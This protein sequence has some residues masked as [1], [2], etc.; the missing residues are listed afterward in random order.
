MAICS[1]G[2]VQAPEIPR[3]GAP[4]SAKLMAWAIL[5]GKSLAWA[6]EKYEKS[7]PGRDFHPKNALA[8][9]SSNGKFLRSFGFRVWRIFEVFFDV[10]F[11]L[12]FCNYFYRFWMD[13]AIDFG[14]RYGIWDTGYGIR[15]TRHGIRDA[16]YGIRGTGYGIRDTGHGIRNTW[17]KIWKC[18]RK[19]PRKLKMSAKKTPHFETVSNKMKIL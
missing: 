18:Q 2:P 16:G 5:N 15:D 1:R 8:W 6:N 19:R 9:T 7:S 10:F 17:G 11:Q 3:P 13:F 4:A 14:W 12:S